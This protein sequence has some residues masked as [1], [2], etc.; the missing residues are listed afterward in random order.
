[1]SKIKDAFS[2]LFNMKNKGVAV[3][4]GI[5]M[6]LCLT[7]VVVAIIVASRVPTGTPPDG[8]QTPEVEIPDTLSFCYATFDT[9]GGTAIAK[10]R[11]WVGDIPIEPKEPKKDG[12]YFSGWTVGGE[13]YD[14]TE[15]I[16][17][18]TT[19]VAVWLPYLECVFQYDDGT[20]NITVACKVG[21]KI[22]APERVPHRTD[23]YFVG[24]CVGDE[25]WDFDAAVTESITLVPSY[26]TTAELTLS[27]GFS[28]FLDSEVTL[29]T[30]YAASALKPVWGAMAER[31]DVVFRNH[32]SSSADRLSSV[33]A[34]GA[35]LI[36][37]G[38]SELISIGLSEKGT[39]L[40]LRDYL[41][42]M[43]N[44]SA[45]LERNPA[46]YL[47]LFAAS[48]DKALYAIPVPEP[49]RCP[50]A[51]PL[52]NGDIVRA[53]LD[54][55]EPFESEDEVAITNPKCFPTISLA[56]EINV[57]IVSDSGEVSYFTKP[58]IR[59]G[60]VLSLMNSLVDDI[61]VRRIDGTSAVKIL[62]DYID[63]MYGT[64]LERRSDLF[65]G[66]GAMYDT[67]ELI[68]LLRCVMLNRETL[69]LAAESA[70]ISVASYD[71]LLILT[72]MIFGSR[73]L[74]SESASLYFDA[75]GTLY[76]SR[77]NESSYEA[78]R[79]M[80]AMILEGLVKVDAGE[81]AYR[82]SLIT[83]LRLENNDARNTDSDYSVAMPPLAYYKDFES[84]MRL[85]P[86]TESYSQRAFSV[87]GTVRDDEVKLSAVL[88]IIDYLYSEEGVF[89][90]NLGTSPFRSGGLASELSTGLSASLS[91]G[92]YNAFIENYL[93]ALSGGSGYLSFGDMHADMLSKISEYISLGAISSY[94]NLWDEDYL[95][96]FVPDRLPLTEY[97]RESLLELSEIFGDDG[98]F[99]FE[100]E[101]NIFT[102]ILTGNIDSYEGLADTFYQAG[103]SEYLRILRYA[104]GRLKSYYN[105]YM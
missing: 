83:L 100:N 64:R 45:Y 79:K 33:A 91:S 58:N 5:Q 101:E 20:E 6:A 62:R 34:D 81:G 9:G 13:A 10:Q 35:E 65:L 90:I 76:D 48:S 75:D 78:V 92:D 1:M 103:G 88:E 23:A 63:A 19:L 56:T 84:V 14:F 95:F 21:D 32:A 73:G 8:A 66:E 105:S 50:T 38:L 60:N 51:L 30:V 97:N 74:S 17:K 59:H 28:P 70:P 67:D 104:V 16:S 12:F 98:E 89:E 22:T 40:N 86:G 55:D 29:D 47:S 11:V 85:L 25:V 3:L 94:H 36:Y 68:A 24:W 57:P 42:R 41:E 37:G 72:E 2:R 27:L 52:I 102:K 71:E 39:L 44:L 93:G 26:S 77:A 43:P 31:F 61:S 49:Y 4:F 15:G 87:L 7:A 54:G 96:S 46:V 80:R 53:L 82:D 99:S 69:G 18:D